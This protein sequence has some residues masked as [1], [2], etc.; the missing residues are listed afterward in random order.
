MRKLIHSCP[1]Q[2]IGIV[3]GKIGKESVNGKDT[4]EVSLRN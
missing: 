3:I 1:R 2:P 4:R